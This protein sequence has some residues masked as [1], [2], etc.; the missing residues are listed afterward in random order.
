[1]T[2]APEKTASESPRS[3]PRVRE[4]GR[5]RF[6]FESILIVLSVLLGFALTAWGERRT[7]KRV[8]ETALENFRAEIESNLEQ[9]ERVQPKH[10]QFAQRL[11]QAADEV[12]LDPAETAFQVFVRLM[13]EGGIDTPPLREAAWE[14][15]MSTGAL[16]LLDYEI[17]ASLSETYFIQRSTLLPTI[18]LLSDRF[19]AT[20]N[21]D[22]AARD[23]MIIVHQMML[24]ELAG[25]ESYLIDVF[26]NSLERLG[27][28]N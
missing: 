12:A 16:R 15:A 26:R 14:T 22:P 10:A 7:E 19:L 8:A 6:L 5:S 1:V 20:E 25:Q 27:A 9:L 13:P 2:L 23:Q 28:G 3:R 17:A 24:T 21:F 4:N 11:V 18:R